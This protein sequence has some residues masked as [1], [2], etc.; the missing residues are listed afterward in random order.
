MSLCLQYMSHL[1]A[2]NIVLFQGEKWHIESMD[3]S[4]AQL[5]R[6]PNHF[7]AAPLHCLQLLLRVGDDTADYELMEAEADESTVRNT[8]TMHVY[9]VPNGLLVPVTEDGNERARKRHC[10]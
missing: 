6:Y 4:N 9:T 1:T 10:L 7:A 2:G 8:Q 3:A 5:T